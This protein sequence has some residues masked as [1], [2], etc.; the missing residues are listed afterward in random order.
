MQ[1]ILRFMDIIVVAA[2]ALPYILIP[3]PF[4][5]VLFL[6][7]RWYFLK[8]SRAVKRLEAIGKSIEMV[9][10]WCHLF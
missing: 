3:L 1:L 4:I 5:L 6:V 10:M 2:V 7:I 9:T 8:T